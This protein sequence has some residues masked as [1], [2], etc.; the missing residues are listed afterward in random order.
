[1]HQTESVASANIGVAFQ[2]CSCENASSEILNAPLYLC[3]RTT[4]PE[5]SNTRMIARCARE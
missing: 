2:A 4:A 5:S 1:M 3:I